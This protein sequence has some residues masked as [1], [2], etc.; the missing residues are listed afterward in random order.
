MSDMKWRAAMKEG[1]CPWGCL[2]LLL[3][4]TVKL[5]RK[6][7]AKKAAKK[8]AAPQNHYTRSDTDMF[9]HNCGTIHLY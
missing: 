2:F 1:D 3:L 5:K 4:V 9:C 8:V 6:K 7:K